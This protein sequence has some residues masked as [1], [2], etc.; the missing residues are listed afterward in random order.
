MTGK[1]LDELAEEE[2]KL[3]HRSQLLSISPY[4]KF[5]TSYLQTPKG[6]SDDTYQTLSTGRINS[7]PRTYSSMPNVWN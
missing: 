4:V 1:I 5:K 6:R 7:K 2:F 3:A